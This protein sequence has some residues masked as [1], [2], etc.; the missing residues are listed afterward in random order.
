MKEKQSEQFGDLI[1]VASKLR[2]EVENGLLALLEAQTKSLS[3]LLN[4]EKLF[5]SP[6]VETVPPPAHA[7]RSMPSAPRDG[8]R[9]VLL[10]GRIADTPIMQ[11]G[12][13]TGS[14]CHWSTDNGMLWSFSE[15]R[16][17]APIPEWTGEVAE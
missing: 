14:G 12:Y 16:A 15:I 7:W 1:A 4:L 13:L 6:E 2:A 11:V 8:R 10:I 9:C 17:W 5:E 3:A